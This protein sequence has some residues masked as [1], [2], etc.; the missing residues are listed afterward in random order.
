MESPELFMSETL[1]TAALHA[2][3]A[4]NSAAQAQLGEWLQFWNDAVSETQNLRDIAFWL[5]Q[6]RVQ[7]VLSL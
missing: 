2:A 4:A 5:Q 6:T 7:E 3:V 1:A